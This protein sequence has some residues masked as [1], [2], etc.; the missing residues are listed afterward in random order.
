MWITWKVIVGETGFCE[1]ILANFT[2]SCVFHKYF[3]F[4][5]MLELRKVDHVKG[6]CS[7]DMFLLK[8]SG[9][10]HSFMNYKNISTLYPC[11]NHVMWITWKV[12]VRETCFCEKIQ[13]DYTLSWVFQK[14][15]NFVPMLESRNVDHVKSICSWNMFLW[16]NSSGHQFHEFFK[17]ISTFVKAF[18]ALVR[19]P[20]PDNFTNPP[21][22]NIF[23]T[24]PNV[25]Y[26][27]IRANSLS[28]L[29][30]ALHFISPPWKRLSSNLWI[31]FSANKKNS[32]TPWRSPK[33]LELPL[34]DCSNVSTRSKLHLQP[35]TT[36]LF[37]SPKHFLIGHC[38]KQ[39]D[40][41]FSVY[42]PA[43]KYLHF[44]RTIS[45]EECQTKSFGMNLLLHAI[46]KF[47]TTKRLFKSN[48][49]DI[50]VSSV[51]RN[52]F[53]FVPMLE[54]RKVDHVKTNC[55]WDMFLWKKSSGLHSFMSFSE[56]FQL[57]T[58]ARIT[59]CGWR[60]K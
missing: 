39:W 51:F 38:F 24:T 4:V 42:K 47:C 41:F 7:W 23:L 13:A 12:I 53:N 33:P 50:T 21:S 10:L 56:I 31:L 32:F 15:F 2:V 44:I 52:Y 17:N 45:L 27:T 18:P 26:I 29:E 55:S 28:S 30:L 6:N 36:R 34:V 9:G 3:N 43:R 40:L 8:N 11:Q 1:K 49:S 14:C 48:C 58:H 16:K 46:F 22:D 20:V 60:E 5:P 54:S 35:M 37:L 19:T 57:C 59:K 25:P